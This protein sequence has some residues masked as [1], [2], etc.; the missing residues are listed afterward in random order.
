MLLR[1]FAELIAPNSCAGC[2]VL[3]AP[4]TI[5]CRTCALTVEKTLDPEGVF[6]YGGAIAHAIKRFKFGGRP[7]LV[8]RFAPMLVPLV[9]PDVDLVVP[10]PIHPVRLA[11][12][13]YNQA[14]LLARPVARALAVPF[15]GRALRRLR[16]TPKQTTFDRESRHINVR[17]AFA[18]NGA[19]ARAVLTGRNVLLVD[20]VR[21]TGS[22]LR[23]C[24]DAL[25]EVGARRV[26]P[27]VLACRDGSLV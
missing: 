5:F 27:L 14:A 11:E 13:G 7:D 25:N 8:A 15:A 21:T 17:G 9:P 18:A 3:I 10:V 6:A 26:F 1:A 12:R 19:T 20:D 4:S 23:A 16:D 24:A 22:T 2:D